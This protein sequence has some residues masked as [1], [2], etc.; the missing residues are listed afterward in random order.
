MF[1]RPSFSFFPLTA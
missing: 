1:H